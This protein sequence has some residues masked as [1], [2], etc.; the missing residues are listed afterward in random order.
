MPVY[1]PTTLIL[2]RLTI[3]ICFSIASLLYNVL[4]YN[5]AAEFPGRAWILLTSFNLGYILYIYWR[6]SWRENILADKFATKIGLDPL[7]LNTPHHTYYTLFSIDAGL[8]LYLSGLCYVF[9]AVSVDYP[10]L[11]WILGGIQMALGVWFFNE[12]YIERAKHAQLEV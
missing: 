10:G 12:I 8:S 5:L 7:D 11:W 6:F 1:N 2:P 9:C 3:G 4:V